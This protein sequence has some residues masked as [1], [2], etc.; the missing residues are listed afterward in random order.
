MT[1]KLLGIVPGEY[2]LD[3]LLAQ[4]KYN[5]IYSDGSYYT[6]TESIGHF[7][8]TLRIHV[9]SS[10]PAPKP[11]ITW[12]EEQTPVAIG[13]LNSDVHK[14]KYTV[15]MRDENGQPVRGVAA[16]PVEVLRGGRGAT[17]APNTGQATCYYDDEQTN[18]SHLTGPD[19][20]IKGTFWSGK[21]LETTSIG[22]HK[23]PGDAS[24][25]ILSYIDIEQVWNGRTGED[26]W[27][28]EKYF[29]FDASSPISYKMGFSRNGVPSPI[30]GHNLTPL[31]DSIY[32]YEWDAEAGEDW[33]GDD[34]PDGAYEERVYSKNDT[35]RA[36]FD[37]W[38]P[39][40]Q[41]GAV[42]GSTVSGVTSYSA[43]QTIHRRL[44]PATAS[45]NEDFV[46]DSLYFWM[47]DHDAFSA[48]GPATP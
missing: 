36:K 22:F 23:V 37:K 29:D 8:D 41:W 21:R 31:T 2:T 14:A 32:G 9:L 4:G 24:S 11:S 3:Y 6:N 39:L 47:V 13:H 28:Y 34:Q 15:T 18:P 12:N 17:D 7:N 1:M 20:T 45:A 5:Y 33:D 46:L 42:T 25:G 38:S 27:E 16:P 48:K 43:P 35:N 19:G 10:K 40:V 44:P 26:A 30:D